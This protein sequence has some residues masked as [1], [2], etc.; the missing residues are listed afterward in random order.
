M[1]RIRAKCGG[2]DRQFAA[3]SPRA[4]AHSA[5]VSR[6]PCPIQLRAP[7]A[8]ISCALAVATAQAAELE[9]QA[10]Q[11]V[12]D[13]AATA[14]ARVEVEVGALD[15]RLRLAPCEKVEPYIPTGTRLWGRTRIGLRCVQGPTPWNVYLPLVVKVFGA[16]L[17]AAAAL[18]AG[19]V[20]TAADLL[21]AEVDLADGAAPVLAPNAAIGRALARPLA[22]G[23]TLRSADLR[24]RQWFAAGDTVQITAIGNGFR[25]NGEGEALGPGL[26]GRPTRIRLDGGRI[27]VARPVAE[28]H[29]EI[30]L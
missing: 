30:R 15:P 12:L 22:A 14:D 27:V 10:R 6:R 7:L 18:P 2:F 4:C 9:Q 28:R 17:T 8:A 21:P 29:V 5:N 19:A 25:I 13:S 20:L 16:G 23:Q 11:F 26:E 1:A 3:S 24:L